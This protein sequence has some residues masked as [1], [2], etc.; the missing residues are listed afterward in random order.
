M[1]SLLQINTCNN[2]FSTGKIVA[3]IGELAI[4]S[5]WESYIAYGREFRPSKNIPI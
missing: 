3:E 1:P 4:D 2:V 5:G